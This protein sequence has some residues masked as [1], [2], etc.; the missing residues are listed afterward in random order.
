MN[1]FFRIIL[2]ITFISILLSPVSLAIASD[3]SDSVVK[4]FVTANR[5]D[6]YQPWQ[7]EGTYTAS[8]SGCILKGN[9]I[10][11]NAHVIADNT[12][13][14]VKKNSD[15]KKYT[16]KVEHIGYDCDLAVLV[17]KD[18]KFFDDTTFLELGELPELQES[19]S[20]LGYPQGGDKMSITKGVVSRIELV[21]YSQSNRKLLAVQ[22]DAAINPGNSGGPVIKDGKLVGIAM[23]AYMTA[24]NIGYMIP[25]PVINH[26]FNDNEDGNYDGF[27]LIG[28][29]F[30]N[31]ENNALKKIYGIN[32]IEGGV[33]ISKTM[34]NS[35]SDGYLF[36]GDVILEI[37][38]IQIGEDGTYTFRDNERLTMAHLI[39]DKQ[40]DNDIN[41][42]V[43]RNGKIVDVKLP[44][45]KY[46]PLVP[47]PRYFDKPPYY[48]YGGI[49]FVPLSTDLVHAWGNRWWEQAPVDFNYYLI[50]S[51]RSNIEKNEQVVVLLSVLS[52]DINVGYQDFANEI[53][54]S[55]N[56][57]NVSSFKDL[58]IFLEEAKNN[59]EFTTVLLKNN[60]KLIIDNTNINQVDKQI[61]KRNNIPFQ[62]SEDIAEW[63]GNKQQGDK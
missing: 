19:V 3:Q 41:L 38:N 63:L 44:L 1:S 46:S 16:A 47:Y 31:T 13:I 59:D 23:Q 6:Y 17:V 61:L 21:P 43:K 10:L 20:V 37:D 27:P 34:P 58:V 8:G 40:I 24:Q 9:K 48:I 12:F 50:A 18:P 54:V 49:I 22:I 33:L 42:K 2:F 53:V 57:K 5:M 32:D 60:S 14:Q 11:T 56:D 51:G 7:S 45:R 55:I 35:P 28:I 25:P 39:N 26:F 29:E 15:P 30:N 52:D 62:Y 36:E 4:I